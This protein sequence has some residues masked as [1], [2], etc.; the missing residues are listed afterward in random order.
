MTSIWIHGPSGPPSKRSFNQDSNYKLMHLPIIY[1]FVYFMSPQLEYQLF[2]NHDFVSFSPYY[3]P[4]TFNNA[5][6]HTVGAQ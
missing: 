3:T 6:W 1:S 2:E 4:S 5:C